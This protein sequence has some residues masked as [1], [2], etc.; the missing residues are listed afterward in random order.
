[1]VVEADGTLKVMDFGIARL[2]TRSDGHTQAGMVIGTPEYMSPE[3]L[4]GDELDGRSD[5]YSAGCVLYE[6]LTGRVPLTGD[7]PATL[8]GRVLSEVPQPPRA[9]VAQASPLLSDAIMQALEKDREKRP[10][11]ALEF[12][13]ILD[14]A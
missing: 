4:R 2:Q 10:R 13:G 5:L 12:L 8:I 3:Q 9:S 14:R 6:S 7:T 11:T 1:M